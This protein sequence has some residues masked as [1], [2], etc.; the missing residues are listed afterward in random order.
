MGG[1]F[2]PPPLVQIGLSDQS[3]MR[4]S[5]FP[6]RDVVCL[7]YP[8]ISDK[9]S[10]KSLVK[11]AESSC[12][13]WKTMRIVLRILYYD[14]ALT[15]ND[16]LVTG[17]FFSAGHLYRPEWRSINTTPRSAFQ[18]SHNFYEMKSKMSDKQHLL[19]LGGSD[20]D[21]VKEFELPP[22]RSKR[23]RSR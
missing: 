2:C 12:F 3:K 23:P 9:C 14:V 20:S 18:L 19:N 4:R 21:E 5:S 8:K 11:R 15:T 7:C 1:Q 17:H 6:N 22:P 16:W 10:I 13:D